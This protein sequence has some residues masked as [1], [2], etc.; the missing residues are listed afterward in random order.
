MEHVFSSTGHELKLPNIVGGQGVYLFD[1]RGKRFIDLESG[2]WCMA[3]GHNNE[4]VNRTVKKQIDSLVHAGFCYSNH[5]LEKASKS[6]LR[7]IG[8]DDGKCTFLCSGSEAIE[9]LRQISKHLTGKNISMTLEDSY[10]GA[11]SSVT[12]RNR[13]WYVF[14]WEPCK[15]C[16]KNACCDPAC[17]LLKEIPHDISEFI[18]E[19]GSS[20]GFVRFPPKALIQNI[21]TIIRKNKGKIIANEVTTGVGRT[22]KWFGYQHYDIEPDL[23]AMGKGIGNGYPV[24]VAAINRETLGQLERTPFKYAQSHQNDPLGAAV[25]HEVVQEIE[26][27]DLIRAAEEKGVRFLSQLHS[28]VDNEIVLDVRGRGMMFA[29][30]LRDKDMADAIYSGLIEQGYI[31]GNRG[32]AFRIDPPLI[33]S[34]A[35]FTGFINTFKGLLSSI[36]LKR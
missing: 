22:G 10:L 24:S 18:F 19:P 21:V 31:L 3:L 23:I 36:Q 9:I 7:R 17:P 13:S 32:A 33:L 6:I 26:N 28:L 25:V 16:K 30:D 15:A 34:E 27:N 5:I 2:T 20:S 12:D 11:Y 35:D 14:D 29:V 1:D 4:Q 8:F